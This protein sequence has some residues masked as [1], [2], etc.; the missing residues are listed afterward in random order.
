MSRLSEATE[1]LDALS[2]LG[3]QQRLLRSLLV[4]LPA[5]AFAAEVG[6]GAAVQLL[7]ILLVTGLAVLSA[8]APDSH[9][10]LG[11][12]LVVG[13]YWAIEVDEQLSSWTLL[14]TVL[15]V[16]FHVVCLLASYGPPSVVLSAAMLLLWLR[17]GLVATGAGVLVWLAGRVLDG[18]DPGSSGWLLAAALLA[19]VAWIVVLGRRLSVDAG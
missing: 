4:L 5:A 12:V 2:R 14:V 19:L 8:L 7:P 17:R 13:G 15:L 3:R 10:P 16:V 1:F 11:V 18:V 6:A 9:A